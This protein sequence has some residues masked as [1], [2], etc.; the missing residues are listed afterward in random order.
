MS[1]M[2]GVQLSAEGATFYASFV[3]PIVRQVLLVD[4]LLYLRKYVHVVILRPQQ[5]VLHLALDLDV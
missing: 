4:W 1:I 3:V 2:F 5:Y